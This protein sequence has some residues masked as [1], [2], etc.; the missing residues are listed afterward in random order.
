MISEGGHAVIGEFSATSALP[1]PGRPDGDHLKRQCP[2][3]GDEGGMTYGSIVLQ[4]ED[5]VTFTPLYA[6]PELMERKK[7]GL[8]IYDERVDWWSLGVSLYE[9]TT[10]GIP[11]H[12]SSDAI[13]IGKGRRDETGLLFD[14]L[15]G[16]D[17][18]G[19]AARGCDAHLDGYLRSVNFLL[20]LL[21]IRTHVTILSDSSLFMIPIIGFRAKGQNHI[22]FWNHCRIYGQKLKT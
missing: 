2:S 12:I 10:G 15:E 4:P 3:S 19:S 21:I 6:A 7:D 16:L 11:F 18:M 13:S 14:L 9:I 1:V 20:H 5:T 17:L 22:R 8:L